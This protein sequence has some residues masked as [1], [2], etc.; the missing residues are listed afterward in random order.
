MQ[1]R[2]LLV[3]LLRRNRIELAEGAGAEWQPWPIPRPKDGL[4]LKFVPI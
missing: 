1:I 2:I 3:Q 4:P